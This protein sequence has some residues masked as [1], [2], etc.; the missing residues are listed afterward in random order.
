MRPDS[1]IEAAHVIDEAWAELQRRP[2]VQSRIGA[3]LVGLPDLS[4]A[5]AQRRS[6]VGQALLLRLAGLAESEMPHEVAIPLRLVRYWAKVWARE[7]DW[8]WRVLDPCGIGYFGLFLPTAYCGGFLLNTVHGQLAAFT[9]QTAEDGE[10]YLARV[11]DYA[12]LIDQ[13]AERTAGQAARGI[14]MPKSQVHQAQRLLAGWRKGVREAL[15]A[16]LVRMPA[17][18]RA[19][20]EK[21]VSRCIE[22]EIKPAFDR[23]AAGL[24]AAYLEQAP[25][26]VGMRQYP[27]GAEL[28]SDLVK[29]HTTRELT[30]D[31]VHELGVV[32]MAQIERAMRDIQVGFGFKGS[33]AE[34]VEH[35]RNDRQ[36]RAANVEEV[37]AF[38]QRYLERIQP[39]LRTVFWTL[40]LAA[41][42][43]ESLPQ[44]LQASMTFGY[45]DGP[46]RD[47]ESGV[48]LFN[49]ANLI[50]NSLINVP[51]LT[52]HELVP[53]HHLH[54]ATQQENARL[55]PSSVHTILTAFNEGWAEYA[56]ALAG[57]LGMYAEPQALYGRL[58]A[59]AMLT[60]RLVV[61]TGMNA[62][63]WSLEQA[64][65][66]MREHSGLAEG[67]I[68]TES[69]R[70]SCDIPGQALAYKAGDTEIFRMR[71]QMREALGPRFDLRDFHAAVLGAGPLPL[72]D[73]EWHVRHE[74]RK[75]QGA[76]AGA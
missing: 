32:R 74:T 31:Q 59:D 33:P 27:G 60:C 75:L 71:Q 5:E 66:Y 4:Y 44:A 17:S 63:G 26:E 55:H 13:F 43:A 70:Y 22:Q 35:L 72:P 21:E 42:A 52:Y 9:F 46:R 48:Y 16:A 54:V 51:S 14:R 36:W 57:E 30:P 8:Y 62:L 69:L 34:F 25:D 56:A 68:Q 3:A 24:G 23:A 61:D 20:V 47:R 12:R 45:Y 29:L 10:R 11:S 19:G 53:G 58:A 73:L 2:Y 7:A 37:E 1:L 49:A 41:C 76:M 40:P 15:T 39:Q 38:F 64:R 50:A 28:Y 67:E 18:S 65:A 6:R